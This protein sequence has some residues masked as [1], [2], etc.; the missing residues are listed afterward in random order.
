MCTFV[1]IFC[2]MMRRP[3]RS[4]RSDTLLPN[5]TLFRSLALALEARDLPAAQ[6]RLQGSPDRRDRDAEVGSLLPVDIHPDL[7]V[8]QLQVCVE[9]E[10]A[11]VLRRDRKSTRLNSSP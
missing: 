11:R 6:H 4:T 9:V 7:R 5:T 10:N 2:F 8:V 3:P 1:L